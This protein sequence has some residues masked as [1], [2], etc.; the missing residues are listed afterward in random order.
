M[1]APKVNHDKAMEVRVQGKEHLSPAQEMVLGKKL[2]KLE[3]I[4]NG[5]E[6]LT[7][8]VRECSASRCEL[9]MRVLL[10]GTPL[11]ARA[12]RKTFEQGVDAVMDAIVR[13][14]KSHKERRA[15]K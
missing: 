9:E 1:E 7:V 6:D 15:G 3:R 10:R 2:R 8:Y 4:G 12:A 11:F 14:V 13:Q 5:I